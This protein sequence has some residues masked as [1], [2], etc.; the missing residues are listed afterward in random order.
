VIGV[1]VGAVV[2]K[3]MSPMALILYAVIHAATLK[4]FGLWFISQRIRSNSIMRLIGGVKN[5]G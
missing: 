4:P 5:E 2:I 3:R 1:I